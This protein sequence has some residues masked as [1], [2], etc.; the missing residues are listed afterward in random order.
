M[1]EFE[2]ISS[3]SHKL[4]EASNGKVIERV[5]DELEF[6]EFLDSVYKMETK[7]RTEWTSE[8]WGSL[9]GQLSHIVTLSTFVAHDLVKHATEIEPVRPYTIPFTTRSSAKSFKWRN[10]RRADNEE[11]KEFGFLV[12]T[13][14]GVIVQIGFIVLMTVTIYFSPLRQRI[15]VQLPA[16]ALPCYIIGS[17]LFSVGLGFG[18]FIVERNSKQQTWTVLDKGS[19]TKGSRLDYFRKLRI[20][21]RKGLDGDRPD[22]GRKRKVASSAR[23]T[24]FK[25]KVSPYEMLNPGS[26]QLSY[27][28]VFL[29]FL[30]LSI[31]SSISA[32]HLP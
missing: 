11:A 32:W 1:V 12:A 15:K 6:V 13:M 20:I 14:V 22:A 18:T 5:L 27:Y 24:P 21:N 8:I 30:N 19:D 25:T 9:E 10:D 28:S 2:P 31:S 16:Y 3:T 17:A 26:S 29:L 7:L 4:D 23:S